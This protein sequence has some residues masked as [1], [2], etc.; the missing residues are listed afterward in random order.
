M[1]RFLLLVI[2]VLVGLGVA[3]RFT[4]GAGIVLLVLFLAWRLF[5]RLFG[6]LRTPTAQELALRFEAVR[7]MS[8]AQ[9]EVFV[10]DLFAAMGHEADILGG[11]G[12]QGVDLV[13]YHDGERV[14]VQCKNY[15]RPVGNPP[16][17]QVHT[18]AVYHGCSDAWVVAPAGY[19]KGAHDAAGRVGVTLFDSEDIRSWIREIDRVEQG[20]P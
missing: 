16:V 19:T 18:G 2:A 8:G 11:R 4:I 9:F 15:A 20:R 17:Q 14:A 7:A 1:G 6:G 3:P 10:A 12:D 13:V 5:R